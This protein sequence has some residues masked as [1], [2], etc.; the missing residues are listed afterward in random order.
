VNNRW[1]K[2]A[3]VAAGFGTALTDSQTEGPMARPRIFDVGEIDSFD[4]SSSSLASNP[5]TVG[6]SNWDDREPDIEM[7]TLKSED[8]ISGGDAIAPDDF[9]LGKTVVLTTEY[10]S[11]PSRVVPV[12]GT[13]FPFFHV[14]IKSALE[15]ARAIAQGGLQLSDTSGLASN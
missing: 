2:R 3:L 10:S 6:T 4:N 8:K 13:N 15:S 5:K 1:T 11:E 14:D 12:Q 9:A 7:A